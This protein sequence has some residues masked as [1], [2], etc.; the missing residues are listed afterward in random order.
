[1]TQPLRSRPQAGQ[2]LGLLS[3]AGW[4]ALVPLVVTAVLQVLTFSLPD[5]L[6]QLELVAPGEAAL[7]EWS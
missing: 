1:M 4:L 5:V 7:P 2:W 6:V 3:T